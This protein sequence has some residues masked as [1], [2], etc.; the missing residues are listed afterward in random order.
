MVT[1]KLLQYKGGDQLHDKKELITELQ[2]NTFLHGAHFATKDTHV[3]EEKKFN[4]LSRNDSKQQS[5]HT[6]HFNP[7]PIRWITDVY[8]I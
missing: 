4:G 7:S 6:G 3:I 2:W 8:Q 5:F 1:S